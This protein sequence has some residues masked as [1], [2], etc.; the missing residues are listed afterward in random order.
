MGKGKKWPRDPMAVYDLLRRIGPT[1]SE[2]ELAERVLEAADAA[3]VRADAIAADMPS[4][5]PLGSEQWRINRARIIS[6][7]VAGV[8]KTGRL[9]CLVADAGGLDGERPTPGTGGI[10]DMLSPPGDDDAP[11]T[12]M[13]ED[14]GRPLRFDFVFERPVDVVL[15]DGERA[16]APHPPFDGR[17]RV[18][19]KREN[20]RPV[21]VAV[22][23]LDDGRSALLAAPTR[24]RIEVH[25]RCR[26]RHCGKAYR[27]WL[28]DDGGVDDTSGR[29]IC[30]EFQDL[31]LACCGDHGGGRR[32][33]KGKQD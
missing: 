13:G 24:R 6:T 5:A 33:T 20:A 17:V 21:V 7:I 29:E 23:D 4:S 9:A 31:F 12:A 28:R 32:A 14:T 3:G 19:P 16:V 25:V 15:L 11:G 2:D 22:D 1:G 30:K 18:R 10:P 26:A 27:A 8:A